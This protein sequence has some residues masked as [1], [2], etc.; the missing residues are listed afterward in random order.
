MIHAILNHNTINVP[1]THFIHEKE[2]RNNNCKIIY[3]Y[4]SLCTSYTISSIFIY[5]PII[6]GKFNNTDT[7]IEHAI[8]NT[9]NSNNSNNNSNN[10]FFYKPNENK[11]IIDSLL[12][13]EREILNKYNLEHQLNKNPVYTIY[14]LINRGF[15]HVNKLLNNDI[16]TNNNL[17]L[18]IFGIW[19][20]ESEIGITFKIYNYV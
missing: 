15:F 4:K 13:L 12:M 16:S 2:N 14:N 5:L 9:N 17:C 20:K 3:N 18:K 10:L 7:D 11:L 19:E 8:N 1:Q 6:N